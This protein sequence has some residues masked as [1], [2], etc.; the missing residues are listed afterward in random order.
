MMRCLTLVLLL[1]AIPA[2][3]DDRPALLES[4]LL[5]CRAQTAQ[6]NAWAQEQIAALTVQL[7]AAQRRVKELEADKPKEQT[8]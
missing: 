8:K 3:A 4:A 2:R 1:L 5:T 7:A 6:A